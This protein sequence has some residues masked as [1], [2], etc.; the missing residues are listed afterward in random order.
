MPFRDPVR[1]ASKTAL[2]AG[3]VAYL[4]GVAPRVAAKWMD[5][6]QIVS[7][8]LPGRNG[9]R[10]CL[11]EDFLRFAAKQGFSR[12]VE[13]RGGGR[14]IVCHDAPEFPEVPTG[15][16]DVIHCHTLAEVGYQATFSRVIVLG[17]K[18]YS[19]SEI[20]ETAFWI[21]TRLKW[22]RLVGLAGEDD[23]NPDDWTDAG[24]DAVLPRPVV[25]S[26]LSAAVFGK[27][28]GDVF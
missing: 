8:V 18:Q 4:S 15:L 21:R 27:Q 19:R 9:D 12:I 17:A 28:P 2:T 5:S 3:D 23:S 14:R 26:Q 22:I 7:W 24:F 25:A 11:P 13:I 10:R 1:L 6:G 20:L 16:V